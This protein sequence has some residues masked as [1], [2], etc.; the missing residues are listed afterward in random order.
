MLKDT[1]AAYGLMNKSY[2]NSVEIGCSK[3]SL[4]EGQENLR[5]KTALSAGKQKTENYI[6]NSLATLF[7]LLWIMNHV[8]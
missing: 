6:C 2:F 8:N 5:R 3:S 1:P 4:E 7:S